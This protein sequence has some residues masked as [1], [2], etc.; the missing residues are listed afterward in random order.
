MTG[1]VDLAVRPTDIEGLWVLR[2]KQI[3]DDR[4]TVREFY[5]ESAFVDAGLPSLGRFVQV[6]VTETRQ[7]AVRGIHAEDMTKLVAVVAGEAFGAFVDLRPHS[8]TYRRVHTERL[9][10][11]TQVLVPSGVGNGFQ[12]TAP[13]ATQYLYCFDHEWVPGMAGTAAN[14]LD[15]SLA[16]DW[17]LPVDPSDPSQISAKDVGGPP[18]A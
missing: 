4:G 17:P 13:G 15:P 8:P 5:R 3:T 10:V 18:L 6:N 1:I 9:M 16:I 7:G 12:A 11:G 2:M 14:P